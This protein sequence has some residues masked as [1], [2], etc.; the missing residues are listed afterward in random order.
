MRPSLGKYC[1][2]IWLSF[3][4]EGDVCG[5]TIHSEV[6]RFR[7][8]TPNECVSDGILMKWKYV[9]CPDSI[10]MVREWEWKWVYMNILTPLLMTSS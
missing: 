9:T 1:I 3:C 8:K 7:H 6:K 5:C 2:C 10:R 4:K